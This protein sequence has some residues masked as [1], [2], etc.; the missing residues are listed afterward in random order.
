MKLI[1]YEKKNYVLKDK[2]DFEILKKI[3][4]IEK[5]RLNK[6]DKEIIKLIRTQ[7]KDDWRTPLIKYLNKM[8]RSVRLRRK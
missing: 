3:K 7:L 5:N 2:K 4:L 1:S 8:L 6:K